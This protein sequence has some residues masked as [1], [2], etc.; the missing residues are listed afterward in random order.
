MARQCDLLGLNRSTLYYRAKPENREDFAIMNLLD[1][2][3]SDTPFYGYRRMTVY[4]RSVGWVVNHKRDT[5]L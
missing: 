4:L 2:Q 3:Y 5:R 1:E